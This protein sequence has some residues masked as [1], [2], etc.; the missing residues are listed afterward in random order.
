MPEKTVAI[1][2]L[3]KVGRK[4][5]VRGQEVSKDK[6]GNIVY[7]SIVI[8]PDQKSVE[9][10][11]SSAAFLL[12]KN[13]TGRAKFPDLIDASQFRPELAK[14]KEAA[15]AENAKLLKENAAL[16]VQLKEAGLLGDKS[17]GED[18]G[19]KGGKKK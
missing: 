2:N 16:K 12:A 19:K 1:L 8:L 9:V 13:K 14:E 5:H 6:D 10:P 4:Y 11:E 18:N 3:S 15:L 7:E 17:E